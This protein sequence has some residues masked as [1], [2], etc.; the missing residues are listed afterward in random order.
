MQFHNPSLWA[1]VGVLGLEQDIIIKLRKSEQC[2]VLEGSLTLWIILKLW[3]LYE[4]RA[5][6]CLLDFCGELFSILIYKMNYLVTKNCDRKERCLLGYSFCN[7]VLSV[8][9]VR[10]RWYCYCCSVSS[11]ETGGLGVK[12][13]EYVLG[14]SPTTPKDL[15][16]RMA[17]LRLVSNNKF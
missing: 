3:N 7:Y 10:Q 4:S 8:Y 9:P 15:E 6:A 11:S 17:S 13:V 2:S 14:S 1:R 12:M 5:R 16:P